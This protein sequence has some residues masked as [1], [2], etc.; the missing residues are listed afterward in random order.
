[1]RTFTT[2]PRALQTMSGPLKGSPQ[3]NPGRPSSPSAEDVA[4]PQRLLGLLAAEVAKAPPAEGKAS[5]GTPLLTAMLHKTHLVSVTGGDA[6]SVA[7]EN[8]ETGDKFFT[9]VPLF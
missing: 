3:A 2:S 1:M 6:L 4:R 8:T 5:A 7:V 9:V